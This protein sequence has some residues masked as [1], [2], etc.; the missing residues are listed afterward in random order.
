VS[1]RDAIMSLIV[2]S[3]HLD[4]GVLSASAQLARSGATLL[5]VFGGVPATDTRRGSWDRLT[6]ATSCDRRQMERLSENQAAADILGCR[7]ETWDVLEAQY[8][9]EPI[10]RPALLTRIRAVIGAADEI[11][12]PAAIGSHPDHVAVREMVLSAA[13]GAGLGSRLRFHADLPYSLQYG[14][15]SWVTG[16]AS[17][18]YLDVDGWLRDELVSGGFDPQE[19]SAH[20]QVLTGDLRRLKERASLAYRTQMPALGLGPHEPRTWDAFLG[21]EVSWT[22]RGESW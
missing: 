12:V 14:W 19:L 17:N 22:S 18:P 9:S 21:F 10:D 2:F 8:R 15:P 6:G 11:W 16:A 4:D 3:P 7:V 13:A 20:V 1:Y 5:T